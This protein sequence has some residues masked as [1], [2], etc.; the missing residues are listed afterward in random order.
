MEP[1]QFKVEDTNLEALRA[2]KSAIDL[3]YMQDNFVRFFVPEKI[4]KEVL[5]HHGYWARSWC[6][7]SFA[8]SFLRNSKEEVQ[9]LSIGCGL[10]TLPFNLL[11]IIDEKNAPFRF[12]E[13]DLESVVKQKI[14]VINKNKDFANFLKQRAGEYTVKTGKLIRRQLFSV[15]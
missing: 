12:Y 7:N 4:K 2:K 15:K 6:F 1:A 10:D 3:G 9:I 8:R 11:N 5:L 13:C 14:G